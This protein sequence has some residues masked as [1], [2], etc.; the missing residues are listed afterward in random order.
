[1]VT[2]AANVQASGLN[3]DQLTVTVTGASHVN[4]GG[5]TAAAL[6]V[7]VTGAGEVRAA[8]QAPRESVSISG[9]G[10]YEAFDLAS[11]Q[12]RGRMPGA[13]TC[14]VR[15]SEHLTAS[16]TG[17]GNVSY[18]GSPVIDQHVTGTGRLIKAG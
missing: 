2:G 16:I 6:T 1:A 11:R 10:R 13:G 7:E 4:L 14:A 12:G 18:T 15:A 5:I 3:A 17:A 8:G 9:A